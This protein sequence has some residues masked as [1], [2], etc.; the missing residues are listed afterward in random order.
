MST[1]GKLLFCVVATLVLAGVVHLSA[2]LAIPALAERD[3]YSRLSRG[4]DSDNAELIASGGESTWLPYPDPAV[5]VSACIYDL[6]QGPVRV[7][8]QVAGLFQ[9]LSLHSRR[10]IF[11]A[12]TD[13]AA[14]RGSLEVVVMTGEQHAQAVAEEDEPSSDVRVVSPTP[15]G[16]VVV[17]LLAATPSQKPE[18]DARARA[19]TCA[20]DE[21]AA[22]APATVSP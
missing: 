22:E 5:S 9:S 7:S 12:V 10:G 2:I 14:V 21:P 16:L 18:A 20:P 17:R 3:A 1:L 13:R 6:A 4:L 19:V 15:T 11:F 8:T